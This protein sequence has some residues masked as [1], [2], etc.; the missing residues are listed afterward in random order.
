MRLWHAPAD[1]MAPYEVAERT[2]R[3]IPGAVLLDQAD[4]DHVP[5]PETARAALDVL[6]A[7]GR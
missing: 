6:A 4:P 5:S 3:L 2:A 7:R 1:T